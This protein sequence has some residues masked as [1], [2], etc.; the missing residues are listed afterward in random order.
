MGNF[1]VI[2]KS[3]TAV[4]TTFAILASI[5]NFFIGFRS[6]S[7]APSSGEVLFGGYLYIFDWLILLVCCF[8]NIL[9]SLIALNLE[10]FQNPTDRKYACIIFWVNVP[11]LPA[12]ALFVAFLQ[13]T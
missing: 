13:A 9:M 2:F 1:K 10:S 3:I 12:Q 6:F 11:L 4:L 8:I 7:W 5:I